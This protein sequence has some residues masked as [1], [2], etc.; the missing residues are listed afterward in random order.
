V[1]GSA[2][3]LARLEPLIEAHRRRRPVRILAAP[4]AIGR[5]LD[6][7]AAVLI[8]GGSPTSPG[9]A[10]PGVFLRATNGARVPAGWLPDAG[11]RL[12][13]Y[14][15]AAAEVLDRDPIC[16]R[17][18]AV[19]LAELDPRALVLAD[20]IATALSGAIPTFTWTAQRL[21][22]AGLIDAL[23]CGPGLALYFGHAIAGGWAGY[24]GFGREAVA[25]MSAGRPI[26]ALLSISCSTASRPRRGLSFS[27]DAA[28]SGVCA[29]ALGARGR[30]LHAGNANLGLILA[31]I[32]ADPAVTTLAELLLRASATAGALKR[33][34]I[35]G[36]PLALLTGA[37]GCEAA[38]RR[39]FAPGPDDTLP[40]IPLSA[41]SA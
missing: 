5:H 37:P 25:R 28:L 35:V 16:R 3:A 11:Q 23:S 4:E 6:A 40:I 18:P 19:V 24:G 10:L 13:T 41:W 8:V 1:A 39:V 38:A 30:T 27:E 32:L 7:A 36:D 22:Q 14:A 20:R 12:A 15:R 34:R 26:G 21:P 2:T 31:R 17:G 9:R 33:Y 29:A